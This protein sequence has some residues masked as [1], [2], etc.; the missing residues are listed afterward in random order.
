M[1]R[2]FKAILKAFRLRQG[3][4]L[5]E[6][7]EL[8]G[9]SPS[10]Y[11]GVES[12]NRQPWRSLEKLQAVARSL[13]IEQGTADWDAFFISAR[14]EGVLPPDLS[15]M[16]ER[17]MIPVLLRTVD[18]LQLT[19]DELRGLVESIRKSHGGSSAATRRTR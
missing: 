3:F 2:D 10:N 7:A 8:I 12:G 16:L 15:P 17:P 1:P 5:R 6:F 9:E 14:D 13:S 19:D 4:G 11:A 18:E